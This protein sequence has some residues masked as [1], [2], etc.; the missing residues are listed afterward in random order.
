MIAAYFFGVGLIIGSFLNVVVYRLQEGKTLTGR[1]FCPHCKNL[2]RWYDNVPV[3]SFLVLRGRCRDCKEKISWQYPAVELATGVVF[4]LTGYLTFS[5]FDQNSW[6]ETIFYLVLFSAL[7]VIFIYDLLTMYIPMAV[8]WF[9]VAWTVVYSVFS[10]WYFRADHGGL[11]WSS[12]V[13]EVL[14]A[15]GA[16]LFF[17]ALVAVSK[18]TWMGMGDAY[19]ALLV[20]LATGWP[21][22]M[23]AL[24]LAFG[25]G[26]L[27]GV[28]LVALS[29]KGMK[30]QIPFGPFLVLGIMLTVLLPKAFPSLHYWLLF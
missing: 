15:L 23:W 26:A 27:V 16:F 10:K 30:S 25:I 17:Y 11:E 22:V 12:F 14:A 28:A 2:V 4:V 8:L 29:K 7:I 3:L 19:M 1:S 24:T 13:P 6:P 21:G 5:F 20:G 18:E 9:A